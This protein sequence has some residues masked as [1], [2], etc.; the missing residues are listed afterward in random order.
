MKLL[1]FLRFIWATGFASVYR[2]LPSY[3]ASSFSALQI[4]TIYSA[5]ALPKLFNIPCGYASDRIGKRRTIF[6]VFLFLLLVTLSF[7]ASGSILFYAVMF[8]FV[9]TL[10]N[11]FHPSIVA[12]SS[13]MSERKTAALF[14]LESAYQLGVVIGPVIGGFMMFSYGLSAA[15]LTWA[16]LSVIGLVSSSYLMGYRKYSTKREM[17]SRSGFWRQLREQK[18]GFIVYLFSGS[19]VTGFFESVIA[20]TLPIYAISIGMSILDV[21]LIIGIGAT[22]SIVLLNV[23]GLKMHAIRKEYSLSLML[24]AAGIAAGS[25]FLFPG[26]LTLAVLMGIFITGRAGG[27]NV[28]RSFFSDHINEAYKSTGMSIS[29]MVQYSARIVGPI[30]AGLLIDFSGAGTAFASIFVFSVLGAALLMAYR[31]KVYN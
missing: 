25:M 23:V 30:A 29:D 11:F 8:F 31:I 2:V 3:L 28:A 17:G 5:Y 27:L 7:S 13:M 4:S 6:L 12:L 9:G 14:R 15:F 16:G 1:Y 24:L 26:M 18:S 22:I 20:I 21:G 19:F 10:G